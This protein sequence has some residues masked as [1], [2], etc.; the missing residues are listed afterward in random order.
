MLRSAYAAAEELIR[1]NPI[2]QVKS[3]EDNRGRVIAWA[4]DFAIER[5]VQTGAIQC[6]CRWRSFDEPTGRYLELLFAH[7]RVTV[8]QVAN[9]SRQPRN[10]GFRENA[11]LSNGQMT[12]E[13]AS[14]VIDKE[15][16]AA[17][18]PHILFLHGHQS[19]QFSH[20]AVPSPT[21]KKKYL[22]RSQNL[23]TLP[24]EV[25]IDGPAPENTDYDL[26]EMQ[27]LKERIERWR[28]DNDEG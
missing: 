14:D 15:D 23:M 10:V 25:P 27:L 26:A 19:L 21:S 7:S 1:D 2:L 16:V 9:P 13:F 24:H 28:K 12:F 5:A 8:S 3:A 20:F 11:R 17:S 4:V 22:W 18:P 6:D